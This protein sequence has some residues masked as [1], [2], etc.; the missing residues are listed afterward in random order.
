MESPDSDSSRMVP[1]CP[2][3]SGALEG[4]YSRF[5]ENV[6]VC[7]ECYTGITVPRKAWEIAAVKK[8]QRQNHPGKR[9]G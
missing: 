9:A 7:V 8:V 2:T 3:C 5:G 6:Y 4:V 1:P